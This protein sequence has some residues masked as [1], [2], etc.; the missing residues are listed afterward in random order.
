ME[1]NDKVSF[2]TTD[3]KKGLNAIGVR[4]V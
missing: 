3:G 4:R 2:E 1:K